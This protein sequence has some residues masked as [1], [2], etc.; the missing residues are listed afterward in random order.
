MKHVL[1]ATAALLT[2]AS[3]AFAQI[4]FNDEIIV[5]AQKRDQSIKDVPIAITAYTQDQ[6]NKLGVQQFDDIADF[7]PGLEVQEQSANNPGFVIRGITSDSGDA[8]IEPRVS[9]YQ[10]G[11]SISRSRG[12]FVEIFDSAI[13][14]IRGPQP[15]LFGRSALIGAINVTSNKAEATDI[16][17]SVK[18]G[19]GNFNYRIVEGFVNVPITED[20][21]AIRVAGRYKK[22]DGYIEN[23]IGE[24]LNGFE[25]FAGRISVFAKPHE[26]LDIN[27]I[28][29]FQT[30]DNPGTSFKSG[31]FL[32]NLT[33]SIDPSAPAALNTFGGF[34]N[35]Q[36]LG[37]ERDVNSLTLL[38]DYQLNDHVTLSS[39]SNYR[40]FNSSEVFDPDGFALELFSF[41]ENAE[42]RQYSQE[43]RLGFDMDNG[44]SGFVGGSYFDE[45]GSQNV[46]LGFNEIIAQGLLGGFLFTDAPGVAQNPLPLVA[47]PVVNANPASPLF[48]APL[49]YFLEEFTTFGE[50]Q[51]WD[52]FAD[53]TYAFTDKFDLT[54]GV[55]YTS[56]DKTSRYAV[57]APT[58][59]NLTGVG[60][61]LGT[62]TASNG[63]PIE[64]EDSFDGFTWRVAAKYDMTDTITLF[65]N[66]ARGRRPEVISYNLDTGDLSVFATGQLADNFEVLAA[67]DVNAFEVGAKGSF[68]DGK[69]YGD[70]SVYAYDYTNFQTSIVN[71]V[72][73]IQPIN[74]GN[75]S[76]FG[77]EATAFGKLTEWAEIFAIYAYTDA[78]FDDQDDAGNDQVF[79]GNRF[80]LTP[81]HAFTLGGRFT[82]ETNLGSFAFSPVYAWKSDLFFDND[83]DLTDGI[84]DETQDSY[85]VL[86]L[87]LT[88]TDAKDRFE[89][90]IFA[91]NALD[92]N[93]LLDA[94]NTGDAFGIATFI[95]APPATYGVTLS[96]KF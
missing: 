94:G 65:G 74:A 51:S 59:S 71:N 36:D 52:L 78:T 89:I 13:E 34:H 60:L 73:Q 42:S 35:G 68:F 81:E 70:A 25:T 57:D 17:G 88:F 93:Y 62:G 19:L 47:F 72:G 49:G 8:T 75:A 18:L 50:T 96:T 92:K 2:S 64:R 26:N 4:S 22:R 24:D 84:Q 33:G 31:T 37:L 9:I 1:F 30:D 29:N 32:P 7:V 27:F 10:D 54:A 76:A 53:V 85:G 77:F 21:F 90:E 66:Y 14:V 6:L 41:A 3:P 56:D 43:L 28:A 69:L 63:Q 46:P 55:R 95:A 5:T 48:G 67:E 12:S 91:E 61:F 82:Y 79:A 16:F 39:V 44:L 87:R 20:R 40:E 83:N 58:P 23:I 38:V 45:A 11:V 86:D 15:T 80:R